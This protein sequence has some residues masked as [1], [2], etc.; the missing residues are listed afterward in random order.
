MS[1]KFTFTLLYCIGIIAIAGCSNAQSDE[2]STI[3]GYAENCVTQA[4]IQLASL[5][6][7]QVRKFKTT[8][9]ARLNMCFSHLK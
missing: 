5:E 9:R 7:K 2:V 8:E 4:S 6:E 1:V 3:I